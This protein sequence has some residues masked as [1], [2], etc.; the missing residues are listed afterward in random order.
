MKSFE[1][2]FLET[3]PISHRLILSIGKI[4]EYKGREALYKQQQPQA[5]ETLRQTAII[6]STE[7]S[8]R[9]EGII[10]P[11]AR[12]KALVAEKTQPDNRSEQ[13]IA[14]YR[15]VLNTIHANHAQMPFTPNMVLQLHR[16]LFKYQPGE[17]GRWKMTDNAITEKHAD[18]T[19][20]I[21]FQPLAAHL[22]PEAMVA[23]HHGFEQRWHAQDVEP[24]LLIPAYV[25][26]F[27][28]IHPF[29]DGNGRLA[30]LLSLL[31][32]YQAG[33][34][35]G[36]YISLEKVVEQSRE[37]YYEALYQS[38]QGWHEAQH[39]L[40]PWTEYFLGVVIASYQALEDRAGSLLTAKGS[41]SDRVLAAIQSFIHEFSVKDLQEACPDVGID[42]IRKILKEE[43]SHG[44]LVPLG[45]G[46]L[47]KWKKPNGFIGLPNI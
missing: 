41:K 39:T 17:G 7:S 12:I 47:A 35:V 24:L 42:L 34:E 40:V 25:L 8:N 3:Q 5:L 6:Q 37:S 23:L 46:P 43:K 18:G 10:A 29:R 26:D 19:E 31:L 14:G 44:R 27:L 32:L 33:Y 28:C 11:L 4:H 2:H 21:R 22:T 16:D 15:D 13:E 9:I 30:R 38:S 36:R 20:I 1:N 45:R